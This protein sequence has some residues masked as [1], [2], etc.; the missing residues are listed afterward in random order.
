M[1]DFYVF[2]V[3]SAYEVTIFIIFYVYIA[4]AVALYWY[5]VQRVRNMILRGL[6]ERLSNGE[7]A[8][9]KANNVELGDIIK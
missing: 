3:E 4:E 2:F 7:L 8:G 5:G 6:R 9:Y 1:L